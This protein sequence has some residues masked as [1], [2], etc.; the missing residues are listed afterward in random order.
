MR[1]MWG[2]VLNAPIGISLSDPC[3]IRVVCQSRIIQR[4]NEQI[5]MELEANV[6]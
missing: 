5:K 3:G 6:Q 2:A 1:L 4:I